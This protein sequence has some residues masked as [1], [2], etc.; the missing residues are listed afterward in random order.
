[1]GRPRSQYPGIYGFVLHQN[2]A[3]PIQ[4]P[5]HA[6]GHGGTQRALSPPLL[7]GSFLIDRKGVSC[8]PT[9]FV[10]AYIL[11]LVPSPLSPER[12]RDGSE[13]ILA[14]AENPPKQLRS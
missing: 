8:R 5:R 11:W 7:L 9:F 3:G 6:S 13:H 2:A 4:A 10:P 12:K 1:M 14:G